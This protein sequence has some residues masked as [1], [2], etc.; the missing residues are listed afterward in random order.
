MATAA[1]I[2]AAQPPSAGGVATIGPEETVLE[3]ARRMNER[4]IGSLVVTDDAGRIVGI[5]T[6]RDVLKRVVGEGR[7][8]ESTRIGDVM[9]RE[10]MACAPTTRSEELRFLMREKRI[11]HVPVVESGGELVGMISIGDLNTAEVKVMSE[12]IRYLEQY[13]T[14]M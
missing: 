2:I 13:I 7:P 9:T 3:G 12:T 11:R 6:E 5:F 14:T 4:R 8:P 10:V 1:E